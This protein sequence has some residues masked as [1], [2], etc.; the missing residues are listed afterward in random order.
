MHKRK[1]PKWAMRTNPGPG[2]YNHK[3][4]VRDIKSKQRFGYAK[5]KPI[6]YDKHT[7]G[8]GRYNQAKGGNSKFKNRPKSK[9]GKAKRKGLELV[10]TKGIP[11]P[12]NYTIKS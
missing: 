12:G 11:G 10:H 6:Y 1:R 8:P 5:R 2:H 3:S 9:F 4:S 7:P